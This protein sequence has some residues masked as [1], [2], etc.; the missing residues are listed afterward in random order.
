L[1]EQKMAKI[2]IGNKTKQGVYKN[3]V[4]DIGREV[5][6]GLGYVDDTPLEQSYGDT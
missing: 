5:K 3:V 6:I 4:L 2:R 1:A